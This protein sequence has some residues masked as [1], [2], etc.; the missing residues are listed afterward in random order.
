MPEYVP[1]TAGDVRGEVLP[2]YEEDL[3]QWFLSTISGQV[4]KDNSGRTVWRIRT[5][6][7]RGLYV[8]RFKY[9]GLVQKVRMRLSDKARQEFGNLRRLLDR[10]ISCPIPVAYARDTE[11][12]WL[13]TEE[14]AGAEV[15]QGLL[16][17]RTFSAGELHSMLRALGAYVRGLHDAGLEHADL[18]VGNLLLR[19]PQDFYVLDVHRAKVREPLSADE[20][21]ESVAFVLLSLIPYV[22]LTSCTRFLLGYGADPRDVW[23]RLREI[24]HRYYAGRLGRCLE[25]GTEYVCETKKKWTVYRR[26]AW[27]PGDLPWDESRRTLVKELSNRRL[28]RVGDRFLKTLS[29]AAALRTWRN[30]HGLYIR[31]IPIARHDACG[32][33]GTGWVMGEWL[34]ALPLKEALEQTAQRREMIFRVARLVRRMHGRGVFHKDLK[35]NNVLVRGLEPFVID[36]DRIAFSLDVADDDRILNLAQLNAAVGPPVT[37][38]DRLRFFRWYCAYDRRFW[39]KRKDWVRRV[40]KITVARRHVWPI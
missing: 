33:N 26:R 12:S 40:M 32:V 25:D 17:D 6:N 3:R 36:L 20:R 11:S 4:I 23:P 2:A 37:R 29:R 35:A 27:D 1:F 28:Y 7:H 14:L 15:I 24:R 34:E 30:A 31:E 5:S 38:T 22:S 21:L 9:P 39:K 8:K 19:R 13:I 10:R 18:H 16:A